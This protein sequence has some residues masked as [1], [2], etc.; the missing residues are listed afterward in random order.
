VIAVGLN[1][2]RHDRRCG[3]P[4]LEPTRKQTSRVTLRQCA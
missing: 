1:T 3:A 2:M 4:G